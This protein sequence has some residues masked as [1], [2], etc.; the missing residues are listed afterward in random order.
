MRF[1]VNHWARAIFSRGLSHV[2]F[3]AIQRK[4]MLYRRW[5]GILDRFFR[6][7]FRFDVEQAKP[8]NFA[9]I[10]LKT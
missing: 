4:I 10:P 8:F 9:H 6:A 2:N 1:K 3:I 7:Q 5:F